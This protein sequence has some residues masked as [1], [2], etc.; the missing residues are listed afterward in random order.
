ML[1][2]VSAGDPELL[3]CHQIEHSGW[4]KREYSLKTMV[5]AEGSA[6]E[7]ILRSSPKRPVSDG[8]I[9]ITIPILKR[10]PC[11]GSAGMRTG[12]MPQCELVYNGPTSQADFLHVFCMSLTF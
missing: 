2:P 3:I 9:Q 5:R 6:G 7:Y 11:L 4:I 1:A 8:K 12:F 10:G